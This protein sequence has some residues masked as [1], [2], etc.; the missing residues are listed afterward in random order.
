MGQWIE[1]EP[2]G[3]GPIA[4][5]RA[6]P[7]GKPLG[8][9]VVIQEIFGVNAHIREVTDRFAAEG[10]LAVAP[11]IFDHVEKGFDVGY[12]AEVAR[13][14]DALDGQARFRAGAARRGGRH[15]SRQRR[16]Q[17]R[18]RRLLL[19]RQRRLGGGR[20][21]AR[22]LR[23]GR[24][25]RRADPADAGPEPRV[26]ILLHFGEKDQHIP[27]AGVKALAAAQPDVPIAHL[28]GRPRLQLRSPGELRRPERGAG[29]GTHAGVLRRPSRVR[30]ASRYASGAGARRV[31]SRAAPPLSSV[32]S[33]P[34]QR[35]KP[36][37]SMSNRSR[38]LPTT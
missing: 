20:S 15:R 30:R 33:A 38:I 16:R 26:P 24:L 21:P 12:D 34:F 13:P 22:P 27:I 11:A 3:A 32:H 8:G 5:W 1:L 35:L 23:R 31:R 29:V 36:S 18:D 19:R 14:R 4:A 28:P 9:I 2:E 6:D 25:L 37:S 17:G 10:Y 7:A